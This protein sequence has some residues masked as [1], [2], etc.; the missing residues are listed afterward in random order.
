M[1]HMKRSNYDP[2]GFFF[3]FF[4]TFLRSTH[5]PHRFRSHR[6]FIDTS[7]SSFNQA[8]VSLEIAYICKVNYWLFRYI[9]VIH[10]KKKKKKNRTK[11]LRATFPMKYRRLDE[12]NE[13]R[14][15]LKRLE[16]LEHIEPMNQ[17]GSSRL[18]AFIL[19]V[20]SDNY[21]QFHRT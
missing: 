4:L 2:D 13:C 17:R 15:L 21:K 12:L 7:W 14:K 9:Y 6:Y 3:Y 5:V 1:G 11:L 16:C 20:A 19:I 8:R 10:T 18:C